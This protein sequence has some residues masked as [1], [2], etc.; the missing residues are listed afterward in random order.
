MKQSKESWLG[1]EKPIGL[2]A[3]IPVIGFWANLHQWQPSNPHTNSLVDL[4]E[5]VTLNGCDCVEMFSHRDGLHKKVME[6][7]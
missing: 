1:H 6:V 7:A 3:D 5:K 2:K 4:P